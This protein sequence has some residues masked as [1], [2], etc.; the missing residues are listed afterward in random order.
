VAGALL[1]ATDEAVA[2]MGEARWRAAR[3]A[4]GKEARTAA[5]FLSAP[6]TITVRLMT[7]RIMALLGTA[8]NAYELALYLDNVWA[9]RGVI[10]LA[11]LVYATGIGISSTLAS[12]RAGRLGLALLRFMRPVELVIAPFA[13]PLVVA[14]SLIDRLL[15]PRPEDDP[16]RVTEVVVEHI[17]ERGEEQGAIAQ[18]EAE[19]LLSVLEF[20][21]TVAREIMVPRTSVAAIDVETPLPDVIRLMIEKGHSRYPVYRGSIDHPIGLVYAKDLFGLFVDGKM[22]VQG[23]LEDLIRTPLFFAA[24]SQKISDLLRQMQ[25]RRT[26]LA[27]VVDEYGGTSGMVTLEDIIEEIVGEIRDEHDGDEAPVKQIAPGR[28]LAKADVSVHDLAEIT[29]LRLPEN[30][31]GYESLGG[32][33]IDLA[34]RVPRSGESIEI[35]DHDLIVRAADERRVTRVEVVERSQ[36]LP[37][38]AE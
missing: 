1:A 31:A 7:G 3:D 2:A 15:P 32:M 12:R 36:Q 24:E 21:E 28:Y 38:A 25:A 4:G 14:S 26:H 19:L 10:A 29:G 16:E 20:R 9:R 37:P 11:A 8:V 22:P 6:H 23:K 17:I 35:G 18:H 13:A 30:A 5:R 33:L 27:I 34:G